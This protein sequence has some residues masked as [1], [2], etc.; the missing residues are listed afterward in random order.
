[1]SG[2][3]ST[4]TNVDKVHSKGLL[5]ASLRA[6]VVYATTSRLEALADLTLRT[7]RAYIC[8]HADYRHDCLSFE[9]RMRKEVCTKDT[10][11]VREA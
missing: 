9:R 10:V 7:G 11:C 3:G 5:R 2:R 6:C 1:M 8:E 4:V